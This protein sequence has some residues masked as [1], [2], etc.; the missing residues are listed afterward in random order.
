M[1]Y[2]PIGEVDR[3]K[4]RLLAKCYNQEEGLDYKDH[5]FPIAKLVM[6]CLLVVV[7]ITKAWPIHQVDINNSFLHDHL[8]EE[9]YLIPPNGYYVAPGKVYLL[10]QSL[11]GLKQALHQWNLEFNGFLLK[12]G[13]VRSP[14]DH[15]L[16]I[17]KIDSYLVC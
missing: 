11:Y 12:L 6:V 10:K 9:V 16:F 17:H 14:Y 5:F 2:K 4:A 8:D 3:Y 1:K 13:F 7:A 15:C